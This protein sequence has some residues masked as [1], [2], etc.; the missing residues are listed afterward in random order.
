MGN[1]KT[2]WLDW[3]RLAVARFWEEADIVLGHL[4]ILTYT[5]IIPSSGFR[6]LGGQLGPVNESVP[7]EVSVYPS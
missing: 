6:G 2:G 4:V 7:M 1:S 5:T 3:G